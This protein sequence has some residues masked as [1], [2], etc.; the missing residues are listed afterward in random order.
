MRECWPPVATVPEPVPSAGIL[1]CSGLTCRPLR[2]TDRC[3]SREQKCTEPEGENYYLKRRITF[4]FFTAPE[5]AFIYPARSG[6]IICTWL[7]SLLLS[8]LSSW[9]QQRRHKHDSLCDNCLLSPVAL[10]TT[11]PLAWRQV[12]GFPMVQQVAFR[13]RKCSPVTLIIHAGWNKSFVVCFSAC[14]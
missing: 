5:I 13:L 7:S 11:W 2:G 8:A 3:C 10:S 6:Y 4:F 9:T 14:F 1:R 12:I